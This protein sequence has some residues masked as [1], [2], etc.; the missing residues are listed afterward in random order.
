M[1]K[2]VNGINGP[3]VGKVGNVIGSSWR[4]IPY[5]KSR[6]L[7]TKPATPAE[8][9]NRFIFG[10]TQQWLFPLTDFLRVGFKNYTLTNQGVNAAKS[11]LYKHA[12]IKDAYDSVVDPA[13]MKVSHGTLPLPNRIEAELTPDNELVVT[14]ETGSCDREHEFDQVMLLAYDIDGKRANMSLNGLFRHTG[15]DTLY[16]SGLLETFVVYAA[17][18]S[19]DRESQSDSVYLGTF[20]RNKEEK[21]K[22]E[23]APE[24]KAAGENKTAAKNKDA[25]IEK[26]AA[27]VPAENKTADKGKPA[28]APE[29]ARIAVTEDPGAVPPVP[30][31]QLSLFELP[32]EPTESKAVEPNSKTLSMELPAPSAEL[33]SASEEP[34][35]G[36][37][38][39]LD[40]SPGAESAPA[41][42]E[43]A[44]SEEV[45]D[46]KAANDPSFEHMQSP[47]NLQIKTDIKDDTGLLDKEAA[48]DQK[49]TEDQKL[50]C[51]NLI[52]HLELEA[53]QKAENHE[54]TS[55]DL[56]DDSA[57]TER[58]EAV[59]QKFTYINPNLTTD[60]TASALPDI[61]EKELR[62]K[63][64]DERIIL[65]EGKVTYFTTR[66]HLANRKHKG[67]F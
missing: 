63:E 33:K 41:E 47:D 24:N 56:P 1:G 19:A 26:A 12:L 35:P 59:N 25:D 4:G 57:P 8:K 17:F 13:L 46:I 51:I 32:D 38:Q 37:E 40:S 66:R 61:T 20:T 44:V 5:M 53:T 36:D 50:T 3:F 16:I 39:V 52:D 67:W 23:D 21:P 48:V 10:M 65:K 15:R 42:T 11:Y 55:L 6:G 7:R 22:K 34:K 49:P 60:N 14:W 18:I 54:I 62:E 9:L 45:L 31:N 2:L 64:L 58:K 29:T 28:D 30:S 43:T 27:P